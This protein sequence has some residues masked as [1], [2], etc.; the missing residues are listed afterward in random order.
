MSSSKKKTSKK[1]KGKQTVS[2]DSGR[3]TSPH[4]TRRPGVQAAEKPALSEIPIDVSK[5]PTADGDVTPSGANLATAAAAEDAGHWDREAQSPVAVSPKYDIDEEDMRD[6]WGGG[7]QP[8]SRK[9][10]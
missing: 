3:A 7:D 8:G 5:V 2:A 6:V 10:L 9:H 4:G 1:D